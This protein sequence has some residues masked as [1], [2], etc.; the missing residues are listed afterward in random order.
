MD[1][2]EEKSR[3]VV[4]IAVAIVERDG[5]FL[6]GPRPAGVALAGLWEFPGGK[7][8][9]GE[10]PD[11][12]AVRECREETGL[13][14]APILE[15][16]LHEEEYA[17]GRVKL[18]FISCRTEDPETIPRD[19]FRWVRREELKNYQFPAGN[20]GVLELLTK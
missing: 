12:A 8:E 11:A 9:A 10:T 1:T 4:T 15:Y 7:I 13:V 14:V 3:S 20:R 6:I 18:H 2:D 16:Q 19:P 17:H 5:F